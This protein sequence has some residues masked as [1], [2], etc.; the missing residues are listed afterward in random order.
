MFRPRQRAQVRPSFIAVALVFA[1][2]FI[3]FAFRTDNDYNNGT[4]NDKSETQPDPAGVEKSEKIRYDLVVA[5]MAGDDTSWLFKYFPNWHKSIYVVN[6]ATAELT[7][8][9]NKGRE[10]MVYLTY[11]LFHWT[12]CPVSYQQC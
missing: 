2:Y 4:R 8:E 7:V 10:S 9:E 1:I 12:S 5:S 11:G 6:D 3:F